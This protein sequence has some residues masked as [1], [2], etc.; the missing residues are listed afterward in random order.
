MSRVQNT[1]TYHDLIESVFVLVVVVV[2]MSLLPFRFYFES[3]HRLFMVF[4]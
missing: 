4:S 2:M 3:I 1:V